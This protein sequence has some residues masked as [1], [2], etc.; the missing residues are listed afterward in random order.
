MLP[1]AQL[2]IETAD[3]LCE[4][5]VNTT[6]TCCGIVTD[7][8]SGQAKNKAM[9]TDATSAAARRRERTKNV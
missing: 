1:K 9:P 3:L 7:V 6:P 4:T 5:A 8:V 2:R